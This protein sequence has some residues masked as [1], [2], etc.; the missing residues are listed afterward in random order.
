[1]ICFLEH[2]SEYHA[3]RGSGLKQNVNSSL[4]LLT[5]CFSSSSSVLCFCQNFKILQKYVALY[6]T[7]LI[8]EEDALKALQLYVQHGA[9]PNP[10]VHKLCYWKTI[11]FFIL[12]C[13]SHS[14]L[15]ELGR[16]SCRLEQNVLTSEGSVLRRWKE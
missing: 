12:Y 11:L 14:D 15:T 4:S 6:A 16:T 3:V 9:P 1:M 2:Q 5:C 8:K 10:Q 7:H 13:Y